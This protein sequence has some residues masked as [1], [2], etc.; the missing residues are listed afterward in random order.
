M[1]NSG[2]SDPSAFGVYNTSVLKKQNE[3]DSFTEDLE[4]L[5]VLNGT[6]TEVR[7][8]LSPTKKDSVLEIIKEKRYSRSL[9]LRPP[10]LK[11]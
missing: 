8:I 10:V 6:A 1:Y 3:M 5:K 7:Y 9:T 2:P 11:A 4:A